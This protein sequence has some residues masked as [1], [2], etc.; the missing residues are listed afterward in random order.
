MIIKRWCSLL[1][2]GVKQ[3]SAPF[4][5]NTAFLRETG[6]SHLLT[7]SF[8]Q[9][10]LDVWASLSPKLGLR[11]EISATRPPQGHEVRHE[12]LRALLLESLDLFEEDL[13]ALHGLALQ[14]DSSLTPLSLLQPMAFMCA[15]SLMPCHRITVMIATFK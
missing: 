6:F 1:R 9:L 7:A 14:P 12:G 3:I 8:T 11:W 10:P 5:L 13:Y 4:D 15:R 2:N